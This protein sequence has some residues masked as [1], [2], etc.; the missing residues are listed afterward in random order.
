MIPNAQFSGCD[1]FTPPDDVT[2]SDDEAE[3]LLAAFDEFESDHESQRQLMLAAED[4]ED[5]ERFSFEEQ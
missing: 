5:D 1:R 4:R 2:L 3:M